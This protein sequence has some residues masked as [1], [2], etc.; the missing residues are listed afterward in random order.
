[1]QTQM[2]NIVPPFTDRNDDAMEESNVK[3]SPTDQ[4]E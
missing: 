2:K 4:K 3:K 1:M